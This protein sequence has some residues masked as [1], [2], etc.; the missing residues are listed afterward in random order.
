MASHEV[1]L[2]LGSNMGRKLEQ[3]HC[4][5]SEIEK[6]GIAK[7]I[8]LSSF[9][10]TEPM[11]YKEQ[12][13]F[14]NGAARIETFLGPMDL[15]KALK[16]LEK[17]L[18]TPEKIVRYGPRTID[19]DILLYD[20]C[21]FRE[22]ELNI[23]HERMHERAFVLVPLCDIAPDKVHP[24]LKKTIKELLGNIDLKSQGVIPV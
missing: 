23:P 19:L 10:Q 3:C 1:Y 20:D 12:D 5:V 2:S 21:I 13:W 14:V 16:T 4:A 18:G 11:D 8:S 6:R 24:V 17:D 9:Y 22:N 7:I 15:L